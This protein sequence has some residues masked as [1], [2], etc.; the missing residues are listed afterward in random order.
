[1]CGQ[2]WALSAI[3]FHKFT[4]RDESKQDFER[5]RV[6]L[7]EISV[8]SDSG[9]AWGF[10][11][12]VE[13]LRSLPTVKR[14]G[15]IRNFVSSSDEE[16]ESAGRARVLQRCGRARVRELV[17]MAESMP[18]EAKRPSVL[19]R[20]SVTRKTL[21]AYAASVREFCD[22]SGLLVDS[23]VEALEVDK[24]SHGV[25][26]LAFFFRGPPGFRPGEM[27]SLKP[28]SFLAPTEG[29]VRSCGILLFPQA[30][31]A[32]SKTGEPDDTISLESKRCFWMG[33][34]FERLQRRQPQ[35]KPLFNLK[36][37]EY[38]LLFRR[39]R[40]KTCER[41]SAYKNADDGHQPSLSAAARK[42]DVSTKVGQS[43][44]H[45]P[46]HIASIATTSCPQYCFMVTPLRHRLDCAVFL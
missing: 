27:L 14:F 37:A 7:H 36:Y 41:W 44:L 40:P 10:E 2:H 30:G 32:R 1:M 23:H 12:N 15:R 24:T 39:A 17:K 5:N 6:L 29:G 34:V 42:A 35:D 21:V 38:L 22:W 25:H 8:K 9:R 11:L 4:R 45:W 3:S 18:E 43:S 19:E 28:S 16:K 20:K 26:E 13:Q 31:T 33:T 46:R